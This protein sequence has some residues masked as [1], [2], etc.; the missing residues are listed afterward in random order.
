[1]FSWSWQIKRT[2]IN[3]DH[4]MVQM[5]IMHPKQP[6]IGKGRYAMPA[7]LMKDTKLM[8]KVMELGK[9]YLINLEVSTNER[10]RNHNP[11][12]VHKTF[13][14]RVI[15]EI[16]QY[17]K[18]LKPKILKKISAL[19]SDRL[20]TLNNPYLNEDIRWEEAAVIDE[21]IHDLETI[22]FARTR[23]MVA[24]N[25]HIHGET[26][27]KQ[28][29]NMNKDSTLR[30][31]I[32]ALQHPPPLRD[33]LERKS[34]KMAEI[35]RKYQEDLQKDG[36]IRN[37]AMHEIHMQKVLSHLNKHIMLAQKQDLEEVVTREEV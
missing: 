28:W 10:T 6:Q 7:L 16:R 23:D 33:K 11:Q 13:K 29:I 9:E 22:C 19:T 17:L 14:T 32:T 15:D 24:A 1:M 2:A 25:F 20:K 4:A 3:M 35:A 34:H 26:M 27:L 21:R 12:T 36:E 31:A 5:T 8:N 37:I 18:S 30:D